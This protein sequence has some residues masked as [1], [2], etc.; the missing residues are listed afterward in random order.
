VIYAPV[1]RGDTLLGYM[2]ADYVYEKLF[3]AVCSKVLRLDSDYYVTISL[4]GEVIYR[5]HKG[6]DDSPRADEYSVVRDY[7]IADRK[8]RLTLT[9]TKDALRKDRQ[10]LPELALGA[11]FIVTLLLGLSVHLARSARAGQRA[12]ELSNKKLFAENEER[13]RVEA[14]LKV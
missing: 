1:L 12:A 5:S 4:G 10:F 2:A 7:D 6:E 8:L 3:A 9:P 11:G 14:R 13:R